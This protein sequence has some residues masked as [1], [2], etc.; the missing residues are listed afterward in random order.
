MPDSGFPQ[1]AVCP[2]QEYWSCCFFSSRKD[3]TFSVTWASHEVQ[4]HHLNLSCPKWKCQVLRINHFVFSWPDLIRV[5]SKPDL[6][7]SVVYRP[8]PCTL[9]FPPHFAHCHL[10]SAPY[11]FPTPALWKVTDQLPV[12]KHSTLS[13]G[14]TLHCS[15]LPAPASL[16]SS[17]STEL[18]GHH[19]LCSFFHLLGSCLTSLAGSLFILSWEFLRVL[20][21][22]PFSFFLNLVPPKFHQWANLYPQITSSS[23]AT[24]LSLPLLKKIFICL[25]WVFLKNILLFFGCAGFLLHTG[26]LQL[27]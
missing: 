2:V 26:S 15:T 10:V 27:W 18:L 14:A 19:P 23:W 22:I 13:R 20:S 5:L 16:C 21:S 3:E 25:C 24:D 9:C 7:K 11:R 17:F 6:Q 8:C 1:P 12:T 4:N